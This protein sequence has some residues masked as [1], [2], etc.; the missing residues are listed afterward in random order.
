MGFYL[1][2]ITVKGRLSRYISH[3]ITLVPLN[4][5]VERLRDNVIYT[6]I[7]SRKDLFSGRFPGD[8]DDSLTFTIAKSFEGH[9]CKIIRPIRVVTACSP[10][11]PS[12]LLMV[13]EFYRKQSTQLLVDC[14]EKVTRCRQFLNSYERNLSKSSEIHGMV[15][16]QTTVTRLKNECVE[17]HQRFRE[18]RIYAFVN[19]KQ[20]RLNASAKIPLGIKKVR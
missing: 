3:V 14:W 5:I 15:W 10:T 17:G 18:S 12:F 6:S 2:S 4:K 11:C 8:N 7:F 16:H 13:C 9:I 19:Q 1:I 20:R